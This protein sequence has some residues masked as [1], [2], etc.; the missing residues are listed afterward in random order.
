MQESRRIRRRKVPGGVSKAVGLAVKLVDDVAA[1]TLPGTRS[2]SQ[3]RIGELTQELS[4]FKMEVVSIT[5]KLDKFE[6]ERDDTRCLHDAF[7]R[8]LQA[9][10]KKSEER[11]EAER[12]AA[13]LRYHGVLN[14][15]RG[16][17]KAADDRHAVHAVTLTQLQLLFEAE[18]MV[19]T[20]TS[21]TGPILK[22]IK[23][24]ESK[25]VFE[26]KELKWQTLPELPS[27]KWHYVRRSVG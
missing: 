15:I 24:A 4:K 12:Y 2:S 16:I 25:S 14:S 23:V 20:V 3:P 17:F 19:E 8:K 18:R 26:G 10:A 1:P 7:V 5:A 11:I 21:L 13:L 9:E 27:E 6:G 22:G